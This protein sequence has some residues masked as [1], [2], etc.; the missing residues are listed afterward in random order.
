MPRQNSRIPVR[1][2]RRLP[3][4]GPICGH[5][6]KIIK[7]LGLCRLLEL[8]PVLRPRLVLLP[9]KPGVHKPHDSGFGFAI[10]GVCQKPAPHIPQLLVYVN[11]RVKPRKLVHRFLGNREIRAINQRQHRS[12]R[13]AAWQLRANIRRMYIIYLFLYL[14]L[15]L[16]LFLFL[17][18]GLLYLSI[19]F[20]FAFA[21][22][23]ICFRPASTIF[24]IFGLFSGFIQN[25]PKQLKSNRYS[26]RN[27]I[28]IRLFL[29]KRVGAYDIVSVGTIS[30]FLDSADG[31]VKAFVK[32]KLCSH[33]YTSFIRIPYRSSI[34]FRL[35]MYSFV[36]TPFASSTTVSSPLV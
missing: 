16:Y 2:S 13:G 1:S 3:I 20:S 33:A 36:R 32:C 11:S 7:F 24:T 35:M 4:A 25:R 27:G 6:V 5:A 31:L 10:L 23:S 14:Y 28:Q 29:E 21:L 12:R 8:L 22:L 9:G 19:C 34:S 15:Y 17:A 18:Y 26:V 30:L